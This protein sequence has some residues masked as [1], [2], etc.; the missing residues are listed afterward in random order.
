MTASFVWFFGLAVGARYLSRWLSTPRAWRI[1]D[2]V[3]AVVMIGIG[4]SL[5]LPH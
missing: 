3:I 5:V 1:L 2:A 4:I